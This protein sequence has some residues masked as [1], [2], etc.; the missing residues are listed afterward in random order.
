M[1]A[2]KEPHK[3]KSE[4]VNTTL[5]YKRKQKWSPSFSQLRRQGVVSLIGTIEG[6]H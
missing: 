3:A 2:L 5:S 4:C 1:D 6:A